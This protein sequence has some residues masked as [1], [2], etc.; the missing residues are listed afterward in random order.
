M[1][2]SH[3]MTL[4]T[5][6]PDQS[7]RILSV[8][9]LSRRQIQGRRPKPTVII[10]S[11]WEVSN[12][13]NSPTMAKTVPCS[14]VPSVMAF[15]AVQTYRPLSSVEKVWRLST[16]L[17]G[18]P[19]ATGCPSNVHA[20]RAGGSE[21]DMQ[22]RR[23][24]CPT[25][26]SPPPTHSFGVSLVS[27]GV[28]GPSGLVMIRGHHYQPQK[29]FGPRGKSVFQSIWLKC[30]DY[31]C[32][33]NVHHFVNFGFKSPPLVKNILMSPLWPCQHITQLM[34]ELCTFWLDDKSKI[35]MAA[36]S[37]V[38]MCLNRSYLQ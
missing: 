31:I 16:P 37:W 38:T 10:I 28:S 8:P 15:L 4:T 22:V 7:P 3:W 11:H 25:N 23:T 13:H 21:S 32:C 2:E 36:T 30:T 26:T 12:Y 9:L 35:T 14:D 6:S 33:W 24:V 27:T 34:K 19:D 17:S 1:C 29:H 18:W 20:K 5:F